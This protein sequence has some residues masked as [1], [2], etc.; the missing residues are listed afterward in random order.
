MEKK[1]RLTMFLIL[2]DLGLDEPE[3]EPTEEEIIE[4]IVEEDPLDII[5]D[6]ETK[7]ELTTFKSRF[8]QVIPVEEIRT[9]VD[10][11]MI[12]SL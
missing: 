6:E 2:K 1:H 9:P 10:Y 8:G 3:P 11:P 7:P 4:P 12:E 5:Q